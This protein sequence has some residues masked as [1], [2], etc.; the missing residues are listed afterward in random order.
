MNQEIDVDMTYEIPISKR[1]EPSY[2]FSRAISEWLQH[3][4]SELLDDDDNKIFH[5]VNTGFDEDNLKTFGKKPTADVYIDSVEYD[6][7]F[8]DMPIAVH[9]IIIF[10]RKGANNKSY[11]ASCDLHDYILQEL[12][13]NED[14]Q[15][16]DGIV[17]NTHIDNSQIT[18]QNIRKSWGVIGA[19]E[20]TH[21]LY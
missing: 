14:F 8:D 19:F 1:L 6:S 2:R 10:Y 21:E 7:T 18:T 11:N 16:L 20:L 3:N 13:T 17:K 9:T 5:K 4:L 15:R 12:K